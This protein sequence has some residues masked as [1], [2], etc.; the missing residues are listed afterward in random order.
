MDTNFILNSLV[1]SQIQEKTVIKNLIE[2]IPDILQK[3]EN[4][5]KL[6]NFIKIPNVKD[7]KSSRSYDSKDELTI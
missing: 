5:A 2:F 1:S 4:I 6:A 3:G 7:T